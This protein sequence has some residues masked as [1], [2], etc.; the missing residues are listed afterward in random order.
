MVRIETTE[1]GDHVTLV[2]SGRIQ[3]DDLRE[4]KSLVENH[5]KTVVLDLN[6]VRLVDRD[7]VI[8]LASFE[9]SRAMI[10]NC[11]RFIREWMRRERE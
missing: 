5:N 8:F 2:L 3:K 6:E 4:L 10:T 7:V 9:T 1:S 11:P